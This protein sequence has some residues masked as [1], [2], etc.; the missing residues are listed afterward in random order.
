M[1]DS[2]IPVLAAA[3]AHEALARGTFLDQLQF[4][5]VG[6]VIVMGALAALWLL[7]ELTG[8][9]F[10]RAEAAAAARKL[11]AQAKAAP[12]ATAPA[13]VAEP[14]PAVAQ[15]APAAVAAPAAAPAPEAIPLAVIAAAVAA[16]IDGPCRVVEVKPAS[17]AWSLEGRRLQL[18]SHRLPR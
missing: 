11:E 5:T 1:I 3:S 4:L 6:L 17:Q 14:K 2:A 18:I 9:F 12:A 13:K 15:A 7:C 8:L 10:K 16:V